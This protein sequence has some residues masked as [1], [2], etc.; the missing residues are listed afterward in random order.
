MR[1]RESLLELKKASVSNWNSNYKYDIQNM[2]YKY[3]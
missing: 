2:K 3:R 1:K